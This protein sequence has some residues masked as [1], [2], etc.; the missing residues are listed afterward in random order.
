[1][2]SDRAN[3]AEL[4]PASAAEHEHPHHKFERDQQRDEEVVIRDDQRTP[5]APHKRRDMSLGEAGVILTIGEEHRV[6]ERPARYS[7]P[8]ARRPTR[9]ARV[10]LAARTA[11][12]NVAIPSTSQAMC[13]MAASSF[14]SRPQR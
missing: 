11:A 9:K 4:G 5:G 13:S 1:M 7:R 8:T 12:T 14:R 6:H 10:L 3:E 2:K